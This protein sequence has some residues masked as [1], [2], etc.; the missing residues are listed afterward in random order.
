MLEKNVQLSFD[1]KNVIAKKQRILLMKPLALHNALSSTNTGM[2]FWD[3]LIPNLIAN[4]LFLLRR[5]FSIDHEGLVHLCF[6]DWQQMSRNLAVC[7][8]GS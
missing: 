8:K 1:G 4:P 3:N 6:V 7:K 2:Q 5:W